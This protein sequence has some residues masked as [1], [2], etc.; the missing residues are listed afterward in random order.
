[1]KPVS[2][3]Y[4]FTLA[5]L[6]GVS[7]AAALAEELIITAS[8]LPQ[9]L[10]QSLLHTTVIT[11]Q[12]IARSQVYDVPTLLRS[13]AG[14]ELY[15][16]GGLGRQSSLFMRGSE[17]DHVLILINGARMNSATAGTTAIEHL[18]L[19]RIERI[20]IVR[21]NVSSMYGSEAIGGVIQIF[22]KSS[23]ADP[24]VTVAAG[25][26]TYDTRRAAFDFHGNIGD[27]RVGLGVSWLDSAGFSALKPRYVTRNE[28]Y[29][30]DG[31]QNLSFS[32][33]L[34]H[35]INDTELSLRGLH[36]RAKV[37]FDGAFQ[38][39]SEQTLAS[40]LFSAAHPI[41]NK[42]LSRLRASIGE[43]KLDSF[44]ASTK[45]SRFQ[46]ENRHLAWLN[47]ITFSS[48][49]R[50]SFGLEQL[51]QK[52]RSSTAY[53]HDQRNLSS[54]TAGYLV[55]HNAQSWQ[56]NVRHDRYSDFGFATSGL[57]SYAYQFLPA[58][59]L[60]ATFSNAFRAPNFNELYG[61]FGGNPALNPEKGLSGELGV[62]YQR[63]QARF[64]AHYFQS[65]I[66]DLINF[67]APQFQAS[68]VDKAEIEGLELTYSDHVFEFDV[69]SSLTL[70]RAKDA[71]TGLRLLRRAQIYGGMSL[72]KKLGAWQGQVQVLASG[73]KYDIHVT[74][75][76]RVKLP[77]YAQVN[78][79]LDYEF[80][81]HHTLGIRLENLFDKE[82]EVAHG[83]QA[84]GRSVFVNWRYSNLH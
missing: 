51:T 20:E 63:G 17:S 8:R 18:P 13:Q 3:I 74:D 10:S 66:R 70:Q 65:H 9:S 15:Q 32:T 14:I 4:A 76:N 28:D 37:Q 55:K 68:N 58:W 52:V 84:P 7:R 79:T 61:P 29:D 6:A 59:R 1:M 47:E 69:N 81:K 80:N 41:N 23:K 78:A 73:P 19:D 21:G 71:S 54:L 5:F 33:E 31:Y 36:S 34:S 2:I 38:D 62:Q 75:F 43:D 42:W 30:R 12:D 50:A 27:T 60:S 77:G 25:L 57:I 67:P 16:A 45:V 82:Y 48:E 64:K 40:Y 46:T 72:G 44:L 11:A 53:R 49:Q 56:S 39:S 24:G 26:G 35:R 22:T 83:Y